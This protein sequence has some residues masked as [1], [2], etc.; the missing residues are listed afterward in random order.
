MHFY[1]FKNIWQHCIYYFFFYSSSKYCCRYVW[2]RYHIITIF[3]CT[4]NKYRFIY[5]FIVACC[6]YKLAFWVLAFSCR[7]DAI[8]HSYDKVCKSLTPTVQADIL[9]D[10]SPLEE[11]FPL[12]LRGTPL[13][14]FLGTG[15]PMSV[16]L[17]GLKFYTW[18][19]WLVRN[20][21]YTGT[22][23]LYEI[24]LCK[25]LQQRHS[26]IPSGNQIAS[27]TLA[28]IHSACYLYASAY[29]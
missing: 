21:G 6:I 2:T 12:H 27:Y 17:I 16:V 3:S 18:L 24:Y 11:D 23:L 4:E 9:V 5:L 7:A 29:G 15:T 13:Q 25:E 26:L 28:G 8:D 22:C 14:D 10:P 20:Y 1:G 19:E